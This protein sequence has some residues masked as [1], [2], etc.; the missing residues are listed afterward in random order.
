MIWF[1]IYTNAVQ[2][3]LFSPRKK[4]FIKFIPVSKSGK[5][6]YIKEVNTK[7][8]PLLL[9]SSQKLKT[10]ACCKRSDRV[11]SAG[12]KLTREKKQRS[13]FHTLLSERLEQANLKQQWFSQFSAFLWLV[14]WHMT[15]QIRLC[16]LSCSSYLDLR[17]CRKLK[18]PIN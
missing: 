8:E 16:I 15:S 11:E 12:E 9:K 14:N 6:N 3:W 17:V 10:I 4:I 5:I 13:E 7:Y 18:L 2:I 1:T